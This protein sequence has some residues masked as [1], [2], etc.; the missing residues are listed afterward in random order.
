VQNAVVG[1][2]YG[3]GGRVSCASVQKRGCLMGASRKE[4]GGGKDICSES[5][6]VREGLQRGLRTEK[7]FQ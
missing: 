1:M 7:I 2:D 3:R 5:E 6:I 4:M